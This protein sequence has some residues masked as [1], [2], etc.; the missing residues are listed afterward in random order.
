[1]KKLKTSGWKWCCKGGHSVRQA[2]IL[3]ACC[4]NRFERENNIDPNTGMEK[5]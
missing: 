4:T 1:M 3:C 5:I 2:I